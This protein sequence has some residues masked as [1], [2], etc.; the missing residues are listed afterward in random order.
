[1]P[2]KQCQQLSQCILSPNS[3][4]LAHHDGALTLEPRRRGGRR[5]ICRVGG[6]TAAPGFVTTAVNRAEVTVEPRR[7]SLLEHTVLRD[8]P[9]SVTGPKTN[10]PPSDTCLQHA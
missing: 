7:P 8:F 1:M 9:P 4:L 10:M 3:T 6:Q 5:C 2:L